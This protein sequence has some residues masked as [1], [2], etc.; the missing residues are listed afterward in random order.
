MIRVVGFLMRGGDCC[1]NAGR[2][3][4]IANAL[5]PALGAGRNGRGGGKGGD[6][7]Q[8]HDQDRG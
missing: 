6:K 7:P 5:I 2:F 4:A 8:H 1:M 3:W